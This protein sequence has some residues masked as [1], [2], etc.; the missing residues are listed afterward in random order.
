MKTA[1][2]DDGAGLRRHGQ[3]RRRHRRAR[4]RPT[5]RRRSRNVF[6]DPAEGARWSSRATSSPGVVRPTKA[7]ARDGLQRR[8][9]SRRSS[10]SAPAV[11]GG[12]DI[13]RHVQGHARRRRRS[14]KYLATPEAADDLGQ[15]RRL[16]VAE[17][18]RRPERLPGRRSPRRRRSRSPTAKTFRFDMSDLAPAA[19]GGTVGQGEWEIL[20]DFLQE[21]DRRQRH[22]AGSSRRRRPRRTRSDAA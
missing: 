13:D 16:L 4:C 5:S 19:F 22:A 17:Q 9:R 18:E 11:V 7:Q 2:D 15:A 3:H 1:L 10:G 6:T 8:S 21:P 20:Q 12:G 14:S